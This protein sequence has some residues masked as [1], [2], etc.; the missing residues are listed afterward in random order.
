MLLSETEYTDKDL[1]LAFPAGEVLDFSSVRFYGSASTDPTYELPVNNE[2]LIE[3][4]NLNVVAFGEVHS[5][6]FGPKIPESE[7]SKRQKKKIF[8]RISS[9]SKG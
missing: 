1:I 3:N 9:L 2:D 6:R 4:A 7:S 5:T 8:Y